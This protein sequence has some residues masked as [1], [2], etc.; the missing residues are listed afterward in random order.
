MYPSYFA[1]CC[2]DKLVCDVCELA[3]HTRATYPSSNERSRDPFEVVH[4][5]VWGPSTVTSLLGERWFVTFIDGF[6][7]CTW[8][9]VL[10]QKSD[11]LSAFKDFYAL[12]GNQY[13]AKVKVLRSDN[14]T[15]Y[16]NKD[17]DYFLSSNGIIHQTTCVD[18]PAQNGVAERKNRHLLE[19]ARSIMFEMNVPKFLWGEAIKTAAYPINR[20]PSRILNFRTPIECLSGTNSFIVPPKVFGCT[21]FVHDYRN[22]IGKLD[23][24]AIK[25]IFVGYSP[26]Q[27]GYRCWSPTER[28]FFVSMDVTFREKEPYYIS[29]N[30]IT[31]EIDNEGEK[32]NEG[33]LRAGQVLIPLLDTTE[34]QPEVEEEKNASTNDEN[35][36]S[37]V[38]EECASSLPQ[39]EVE[40]TGGDIEHTSS[41]STHTDPISRDDSVGDATG[42]GAENLFIIQGVP[43]FSRLYITTERLERCCTRSQV[44]GCNDGGNESLGKEWYMEAS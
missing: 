31:P 38:P 21:C 29:S 5:D 18:T 17:F 28:R 41:T 23:P 32:V 20:M 13:N 14:G 39:Q 27:K 9:Y 15:E 3:K 10:K 2:K 44:E 42:E 26:T 6:S 11:V 1:T 33:P 12:V 25:C 16:V 35:N 30:K 43:H 22:S 24:R 40:V 36:D 37:T 4:S 34:T 7:R 19:V 8:L